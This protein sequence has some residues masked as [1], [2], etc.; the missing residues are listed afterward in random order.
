MEIGAA[1]QSDV[2]KLG[3]AT[4]PGI[5]QYY[6]GLMA[7]DTWL[8]RTLIK[9]GYVVQM[10]RVYVELVK[11]IGSSSTFSPYEFH[12]RKK[13]QIKPHPSS[14][15]NSVTRVTFS[16]SD[17]PRSAIGNVST[18]VIRGRVVMR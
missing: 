4:T 7:G 16:G 9:N 11:C 3:I 12:E 18:N 8:R 5:N 15:L 14:H 6:R 13:P 1:A 17:S 10:Y 2:K